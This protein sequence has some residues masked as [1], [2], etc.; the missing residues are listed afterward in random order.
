MKLI[1]GIILIAIMVGGFSLSL[2]ILKKK[3]AKVTL[4]KIIF[5]AVLV[6]IISGS[7]FT[8]IPLWGYVIMGGIVG[9]ISYIIYISD[10]KKI[11]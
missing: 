5:F 1:T 6:G 7:V 3:S 9:P 2:I 4:T 10:N 8:D 11:N